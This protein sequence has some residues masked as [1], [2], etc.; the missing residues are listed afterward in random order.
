[1]AVGKS[2]SKSNENLD[3]IRELTSAITDFVKS[4]NDRFD[5]LEQKLE[6]KKR[7]GKF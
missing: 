5:K 4:V 2:E 7:T 3:A 6:L 1:M